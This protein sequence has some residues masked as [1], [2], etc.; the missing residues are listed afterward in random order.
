MAGSYP[1]VPGHRIPYDRDG[2]TK[3]IIN[4]TDGIVTATN[5]HV[6]YEVVNVIGLNATA[7]S[8]TYA[9]GI[10]FPQ[11]MDIVGYFLDMFWTGNNTEFFNPE[12]VQTSTNTTNLIDGTWTNSTLVTNNASKENQRNLI[13]S[14]VRNGVVGIRARVVAHNVGAGRQDIEM[15]HIYGKPSS[16]ALKLRFW[17]PVL[18][19][20]IRP[21]HFD[22]GDVA[23]NTRLGPVQFRIKNPYPTLTAHSVSLTREALTDTAPANVAA[24]EFSDDN[25]AWSDSLLLGDLS[26]GEITPVL[27]VR[28]TTPAGAVTSLWNVR[29]VAAG[30]SYT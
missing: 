14:L 21:A 8:K 2:S 20:E 6:N 15:F 23:R 13:T 29:F 26:P 9:Y 19:Q 5:Q 11:P 24:Y 27:Y 7:N 12:L 25:V 17:E 30:A 3:A 16:A 4:V 28:R 1:D 10:L 22:F 18:D